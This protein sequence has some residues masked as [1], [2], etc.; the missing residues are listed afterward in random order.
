MVLFFY[1]PQAI[2]NGLDSVRRIAADRH[3]SGV[4]GP[5]IDNFTCAENMFTAVEVTAGNR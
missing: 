4:Y 3:L 2:G 1:V 5:M